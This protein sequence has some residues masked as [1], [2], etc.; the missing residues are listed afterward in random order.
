MKKLLEK[1]AKVIRILTP[2]EQVAADRKVV[3][4]DFFTKMTKHIGLDEVVRFSKDYRDVEIYADQLLSAKLAE[5]CMEY[6][7][8][9]KETLEVFAILEA[10]EKLNDVKFKIAIRT[11]YYYEAIYKASKIA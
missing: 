5:V 1:A 10:Y 4:Y 2:K 11:I 6:F 7:A 9:G 8:E 3:K